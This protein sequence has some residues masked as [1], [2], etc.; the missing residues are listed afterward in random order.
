MVLASHQQSDF[1]KSHNQEIP[2]EPSVVFYT[3]QMWN[4]RIMKS[5]LLCLNSV[6]SALG[7]RCFLN[8]P[9]GPALANPPK[10]HN[11]IFASCYPPVSPRL[12]ARSDPGHVIRDC[13][14][15]AQKDKLF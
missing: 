6:S 7:R 9:P 11:I 12:I 15:Y 14:N 4:P 8:S 13:L 5:H 2:T 1:S 10:S 3:L